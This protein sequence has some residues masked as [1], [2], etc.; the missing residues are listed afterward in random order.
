MMIKLILRAFCHDVKKTDGIYVP[1]NHPISLELRQILVAALGVKYKGSN[2][3]MSKSRASLP[4]HSHWE[5]C[6]HG[7][8]KLRAHVDS[9][10]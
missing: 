8:R 9:P 4:S 5:P 3:L 2:V 1:L 6:R 10:D 7:V